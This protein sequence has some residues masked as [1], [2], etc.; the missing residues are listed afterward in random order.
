[1]VRGGVRGEGGVEWFLKC[2]GGRLRKEEEKEE[3]RIGGGKEG[4]QEM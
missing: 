2:G 1:V 4:K 3:R